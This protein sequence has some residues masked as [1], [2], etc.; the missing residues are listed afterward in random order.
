HRCGKMV[1]PWKGLIRMPSKASCANATAKASTSAMWGCVSTLHSWRRKSERGWI[2]SCDSVVTDV[3]KEKGRDGQGARLTR[4]RHVHAIVVAAVVFA[5]S[6]VARP[7]GR[8][9]RMRSGEGSS[10]YGKLLYEL[11][12]S[13]R[14]LA[15]AQLD[16]S[17]SAVTVREKN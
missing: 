9:F 1:S 14:L 17:A 11:K 10:E 5:P 12:T 16:Q 15:G 7:N 6:V 2:I 8:S 4:G 13:G 3:A